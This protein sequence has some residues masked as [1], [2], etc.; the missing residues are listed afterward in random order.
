MRVQ[1]LDGRS[2]I[3][4]LSPVESKLLER[5]IKEEKERLEFSYKLY[6][7]Q[8]KLAEAIAE[9]NNHIGAINAMIAD[10]VEQLQ[11]LEQIVNEGLPSGG[12]GDGI[13]KEDVKAM[14]YQYI[15][16]EIEADYGMPTNDLFDSDYKKV[17]LTG[18]ERF[19]G[20]R[21]RKWPDP[22]ARPGVAKRYT[23]YLYS[24]APKDVDLYITHDDNF[25]VYLND[26]LVKELSGSSL[27][28][29]AERVTLSLRSGWN[30]AQFLLS[31]REYGSYYDIG[32]NLADEVEIVAAALPET[33]QVD[34]SAILPG[35]VKPKHIDNSEIFKF[36]NVS[37]SDIL[38][39]KKVN[40]GKVGMSSSGNTV[41]VDGNL[42]VNGSLE[43]KTLHGAGRVVT[44][45]LWIAADVYL[46]PATAVTDS[47]ACTGRALFVPKEAVS[48]VVSCPAGETIHP[49]NYKLY[50]RIK[51]T[52]I[53]DPVAT[54][55]IVADGAV[56]KSE[57]IDTAELSTSEYRTVTVDFAHNARDVSIELTPVGTMDFYVDTIGVQMEV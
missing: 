2:F 1:Q 39:A 44:S 54:V 53:G 34:D 29:P 4:T 31:N 55:K 25:A 42:V 23:V 18:F 56:L 10:I 9:L 38:D 7:R 21:L 36:K 20:A 48:S 15:L 57:V 45:A 41:T 30:K 52:L 12:S 49:G 22:S 17:I 19:E 46:P 50:L 16:E 37:V 6:G 27:S 47:T 5:I 40:I 24:S 43:Y 32:V 26:K 33:K 8:N 14:L 11:N 28:G 35:A 3:K 13:S 51:P